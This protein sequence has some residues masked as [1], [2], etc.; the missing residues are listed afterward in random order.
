MSEN[1]ADTSEVVDALST[2]YEGGSASLS[3]DE[4]EVQ[5]E[6]LP[7]ASAEGD[8]QGDDAA[9]SRESQKYRRRAQTAESE[10]DELRRQLDNQRGAIVAAAATAGGIDAELLS[11]TGVS[12][13][14]V[15]DD[16]GLIDVDKLSGAIAAVRERYRIPAPPRMPLPNAHQGRRDGGPAGQSWQ[17]VINPNRG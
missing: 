3:P 6:P 4:G 2:T 8:D 1:T 12:A 17:S 9:G 5:N 16:A 10:R 15:L 13:A 14:D 11:A 7:A